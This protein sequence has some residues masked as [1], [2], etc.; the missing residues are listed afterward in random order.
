MKKDRDTRRDMKKIRLFFQ[1]LTAV[2][3]VGI[4]GIKMFK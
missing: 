2:L 4:V 1:V 3:G